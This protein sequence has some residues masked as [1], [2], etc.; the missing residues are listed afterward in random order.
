MS[1]NDLIMI[2]WRGQMTR[3]ATD[4]FAAFIGLDWADTKHDICLP[5]LLDSGVLCST[6]VREAALILKA[7]EKEGLQGG[8]GD[9]SRVGRHRHIHD[10]GI[11]QEP[12]KIDQKSG[13]IPVQ[14]RLSDETQR[15]DQ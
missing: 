1:L 12:L 14:A 3:F 5:L 2:D 7:I 13:K 6:V 8:E 9:K 4:E 10:P 11:Q 15:V